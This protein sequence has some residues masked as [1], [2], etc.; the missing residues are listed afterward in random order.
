MS[1]GSREA[2]QRAASIVEDC[3]ALPAWERA[4]ALI[5]HCE[6]DQRLLSEA[7]NLLLAT[8]E[9]DGFETYAVAKNLRRA[10]PSEPLRG[11]DSESDPSPSVPSE[12][13]EVAA[14]DDARWIGP[15]RLIRELGHGG[16]GTVYLAEQTDPVERQV[17]VKVAFEPL[18]P[19]AQLRLTSE[20]QAMAH[21][22]H[23]NI[24]QILEAGSTDRGHPYFA[25]EYVAGLPLLSFCD[26]RRLDIDRRL[27][28]FIDV[29]AGVEHAHQNGILH[30]DLKPS[31]VLVNNQGHPEPKIIDFGIAKGLDRPLS[32]LSPK[33]GLNILGT[34]A[35]MCPEAVAAAD[36]SQARPILDTRSDIF[37]LGVMLQELLI[38]CR[39]LAEIEGES[40]LSMLRRLAEEEPKAM[41]ARWL[42]LDET[43]RRSLACERSTS[44][45]GLFKKIRGD[46]ECIVRKATARDRSERY[47]SV[48]E[49]VADLRRHLRHEPVL[50]GSPTFAYRL[51][52]G[53]RRHRMAVGFS[54]LVLSVLTFGLVAR[55]L[56]AARANREAAEARRARDE[57]QEVVTFLTSIL[58]S[59]NPNIAPGEDPTASQILDRGVERLEGEAFAD[60]P[61]IR[62]RL[63]GTTSRVLWRLGHPERA[64]EL[65]EENLEILRRQSP[66]DPEATLESLNL[67]GMLAGEAGDF[68]RSLELLAECLEK[69]EEIHGPESVE[70]ATLLAGLGSVADMSGRL[71]DAAR[72]QERALEIREQQMDARSLPVANSLNNLGLLRLRLGQVKEA[73][74]LLRRALDLQRELQPENHPNIAT[75]LNNLGD[76]LAAEGRA[77]EARSMYEEALRIRQTALGP[78]HVEFASTLDG[79]G[80]LAA[81][82]GNW[83][84]AEELFQR[85]QP[86]IERAVGRTHPW[87]AIPTEN[88]ALLH[89]GMGD[90]ET[91]EKMLRQALQHRR[92]FEES[93]QTTARTLIRLAWVLRLQGRSEEARP[94]LEE[95]A[96]LLENRSG[97]FPDSAYLAT[98]LGYLA[99]AR[100]AR[101]DAERHLLSARSLAETAGKS[102]EA[103]GGALMGLAEVEVARNES[104][105]AVETAAAGVDTLASSLPANHAHLSAAKTRL[106]Q[107]KTMTRG[108]C[109]IVGAVFRS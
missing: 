65:A 100:R 77:E 62:A 97:T 13:S 66:E 15:F 51:S 75:S 93:K 81:Q 29:C 40:A 8:S 63:L 95:A 64:L 102:G 53:I 103:L 60:R 105:R 22:S 18:G 19:S 96:P 5:E 80:R 82:L 59:A 39:P 44:A 12:V 9:A 76:L 26:E 72:F 20:R 52:R 108:D 99:L 16:M 48:S 88:L 84:E 10:G 36:G 58:S 47:P 31:N 4:E 71:A 69:G 73:E 98:E 34:P 25:M 11:G 24:A 30:R 57:T 23:R 33:T 107:L 74:H 55:T 7:L 83:T 92:K 101:E 104:C 54:L 85:V 94:Y 90:L 106:E 32:E 35:Y 2:W 87:V 42:E 41:S 6:G 14:H 79:L 49:L 3:L 43:S 38:G 27:H 46:L 67:V 37:S 61:R 28:L 109:G 78:D 21:L 91:A 56:E 17:A 1:T 89:Q 45:A 50:A 68:E 86:I 70:V